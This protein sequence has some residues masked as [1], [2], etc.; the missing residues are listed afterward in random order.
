ML[1]TVY[2]L[3]SRR[4]NKIYIGFTSNLVYRFHSHNDLSKKGWT[5]NFRPWIVIY[6][7][8]FEDKIF[9]QKREKQLK[10][11]KGREWIWSTMKQ[12]LDAN[13]FISA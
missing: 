12:Q 2:I 5:N 8:Y 9:A 4:Y 3:F 13:G 7:E 1:Y 11:G 10:T 6:C